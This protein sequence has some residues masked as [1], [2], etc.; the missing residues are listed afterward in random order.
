LSGGWIKVEKD[1]R[2]DLRVKRMARLLGERHPALCNAGAFQDSVILITIVVGALNQLW[3]HAD[4][5]A[6]DDDTL[7]ITCDEIDELAG[8]Q[9]FAQILPRDWLQIV[10]SECVELPGFQEHNGSE[11]KRKAQTAKRVSKHRATHGK[12]SSV[13]ETDQPVTHQRYQTRPDQT[14]PR[15]D[16]T[17]EEGARK[18]GG[19]E[20]VPCPE[21]DDAREHDRFEALRADYPECVGSQD[22]QTAEHHARL[23]VERE[24]TTW[25]F[26]HERV[27]R[28]GAYVK[29]GGVSGPQYVMGPVTYFT[30][31]D[32]PWS[33]DWAAPPTKAEQRLEGNVS[34]AAEAK[35]RIFGE[36]K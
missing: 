1:L 25:D 17:C 28:Y 29:A 4:T 8:I 7:D 24:Q 33:Q 26:L 14:R 11:A 9:G 35:R 3:M 15:P 6:R 22:W 21:F 16:Q 27:R 23:L 30:R 13:T 32:K 2:E 20:H 10:D 18:N 34:A 31:R 36:A 12:R 5:F 19:G